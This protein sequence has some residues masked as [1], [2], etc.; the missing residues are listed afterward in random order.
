MSEF[1]NQFCIILGIVGRNE[2]ISQV[3]KIMEIQRNVDSSKNETSLQ[4][5]GKNKTDTY[6]LPKGF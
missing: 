4:V 2:K 1:Y 3:K 5:K 6:L